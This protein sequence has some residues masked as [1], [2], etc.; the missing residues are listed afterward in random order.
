[1]YAFCECSTFT[2]IKLKKGCVLSYLL[3]Y[4]LLLLIL[5]KNYLVIEYFQFCHNNLLIN[6]IILDSRLV[7]ILWVFNLNIII[8]KVK[9]VIMILLLILLKNYLVIEL[10]IL[11]YRLLIFDKIGNFSSG[12]D[13]YIFC[14]EKNIHASCQTSLMVLIFQ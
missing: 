2:S 9:K 4:A 6:L 7:C 14:I 8:I 5:L 1:M 12:D 11:L 13:D 10:P 3:H